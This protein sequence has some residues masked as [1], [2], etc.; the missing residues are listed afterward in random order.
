MA[1]VF[2]AFI[3]L[4]FSLVFST[5]P[6]PTLK[7]TCMNTNFK[8][9]MKVLKEN[10]ASKQE[11]SRKHAFSQK[12][13]HSSKDLAY[14][15]AEAFILGSWVCSRL[16]NK[17]DYTLTARLWLLYTKVTSCFHTKIQKTPLSSNIQ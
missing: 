12:L 10:L 2:V 4:C 3:A 6:H 13:G 15:R 1:S 8:I 16:S 7:N 5:L 17:T 9:L 14:K 11:V